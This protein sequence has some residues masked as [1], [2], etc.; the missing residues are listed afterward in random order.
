MIIFQFIGH[1]VLRWTIAPLALPLVFLLNIPLAI[2]FQ[3]IY[4][5][6]LILQ[7]IF[8]LFAI[9]GWVFENK[10]MRFFMDD[11]ISDSLK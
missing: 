1:R 7:S 11:S 3:G 9:L 8:Y 10:K 6:L 4:T 2:E 5:W